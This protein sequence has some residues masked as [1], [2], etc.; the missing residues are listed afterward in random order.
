[1]TKNEYKSEI[2]NIYKTKS[3][4]SSKLPEMIIF[5]CELM[6]H[7]IPNSQELITIINLIQNG[8]FQIDSMLNNSIIKLDIKVTE[9]ID[10][11]GN[12]IIIDIK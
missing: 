6:N 10:K 8:M 2:I 9:V 4:N 11:N 12:R 5:Y 1:M 3:I 7:K